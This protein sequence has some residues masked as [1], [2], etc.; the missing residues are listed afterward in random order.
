MSVTSADLAPPALQGS[1]A[2]G[3]VDLPVAGMTCGAC[4]TRLEKAL[5]AVP[6]ITGATVNFATE[7]ASVSFDPGA[8]GTGD[9]SAAIA[10]AG[11]QVPTQ[12]FS[13][14]VEGMTCSACSGRIEKALAAVDGVASATVN[15]ALERADVTVW[16]G[17]VGLQALADAVGRAGYTARIQPSGDSRAAADEAE[18]ERDAANLRRE[19]YTL[20]AAAAFAAPLLVQMAIMTLAPWTGFHWHLPAWVE[21]LLATPVQFVIGARFYRS[22]WKALRSGS[23]NMDVLVALGT[24]A[25]FGYSLYLLATLGLDGS[26]GRLYFEAAVVIITLVLLGKFLEARA[27]RGTTAAIRQLMDLRPQTARVRRADGS[28]AEVPVAEVRA[29]D[30]V[31]VRPGE[32]IPVDGEVTAGESEVD[33]ALIT[34]ESLPVAK[35]AGARV[36]GGAINGTGLLEVR[37]TAV[38]EDS[39]LSRIIRL[40]ENAQSGKA[41]VQRLVDRI[42]AIFVPVV[43]AIAAATFAVTFFL[44]GSFEPAFVAAVSVLV[45][46]CPCALGLAT[47]TAIMTGTGAAARAGILIKDVESLERAHRIDTVIF[48]KTGTL[49]EGRPEVVEMVATGASHD[50]LLQLTASVQRASEHP[51]ARAFMSRAS[52]AGI[53]LL[54]VDEFRSVTGQGVFGTVA[55]RSIAIGN[56][57]FMAGRGVDLAP[58][59][60]AAGRWQAAARTVVFAADGNRLLGTFAIAD[61]VRPQSV[62]A[63]RQLRAMGVKT[64]MLSG[65]TQPVASAIGREVGIDEARGGVAPDGKAGAVTGLSAGGAVVAMVGDGI[66]DAPALAAAD[67]G[68]AMG[69]GTDIAMETA[70]ITLMRNDPRLVPGAIAASRA[71]F[72]KIRQ[73]LFW[74]FIYNVIGIPLAALGFLTPALAGAAMAASSVSVV[75]N[76]LL[77]RRWKPRS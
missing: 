41:P 21:L 67:V 49:T 31:V 74:A 54:A 15:L 75:S 11:F 18:R 53:E 10:R 50:E 32:R 42:S 46:A 17:T 23:A 14:P 29:G 25:A 24:S 56:A 71:T 61:P 38:G 33:E 48:D 40:V 68:I 76:S 16:S 55:G 30:I 6:G 13:F 19:L 20:L 72:R 5:N 8:L 28:E 47:P 27:K 60:E 66:N 69:S 62:E 65:D 37:A 39:T 77:L 57:A 9:V 58:A 1:P 34:G 44:A 22:A 12:A 7:R 70:G 2:A 3:R 4:A 26:M 35:A 51:L 63:I 73:N 45:I 43:V 52:D 64:L 59:Q 36:T